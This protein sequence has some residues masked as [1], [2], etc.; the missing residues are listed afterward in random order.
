MLN[1]KSYEGPA[2]S[3]QIQTLLRKWQEDPEV[4]FLSDPEKLKES[5]Y[6]KQLFDMMNE[7]T[8][9]V[10]LR[11]PDLGFVHYH[12]L[13]VQAF[14]VNPLTDADAGNSTRIAQAWR[15]WHHRK[16]SSRPEA[17]RYGPSPFSTLKEEFSTATTQRMTAR[18][19][20]SGFFLGVEDKAK[21]DGLGPV[22][23][24]PRYDS[25]IRPVEPMMRYFEYSE[26]SPYAQIAAKPF[27]ALAQE[28]E[29][30]LLPSPER[31]V[32]LRK[33]LESR[34]CV[35]RCVTDRLASEGKR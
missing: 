1:S 20:V 34:D 35:M 14:G 15:Q 10:L 2:I 18:D 12:S 9:E 21:L 23:H 16:H 31:T 11:E 22:K 6:Y 33:L 32:A 7:L 28:I 30:T 4:M 24:D 17:E 3:T 27:L 26:L 8:G 25:L 19:G 5:V 13:L 29:S